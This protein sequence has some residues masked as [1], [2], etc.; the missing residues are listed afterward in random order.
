[1]TISR[2]RKSLIHVAKSQL[3]MR[4]EDYRALLKRVAGVASSVDLDDAGFTAVMAELERL[5][6]RNTRG[7]PQL[8]HRD[9]MAT[10]AQIGKIRAL[11]KGYTGEDDDLRLSRW[12]EKKFHVSHVNFLPGE[13]A[14]KVIA[15]LTRM[16]AHPNAK[17]PVGKKDREPQAT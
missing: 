11:F 13:R 9:G 8:S 12:I 7:R 6:F 1:V 3:A 16:N 10:P 15:I 14:G 4:D 5:G 2:Q 17:R